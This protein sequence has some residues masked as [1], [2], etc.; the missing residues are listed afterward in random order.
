MSIF[1]ASKLG[2]FDMGDNVPLDLLNYHYI[3]YCI[4]PAIALK[5]MFDRCS[6][7]GLYIIV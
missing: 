7:I 5:V 2:K 6:I 3:L 1:L 4:K